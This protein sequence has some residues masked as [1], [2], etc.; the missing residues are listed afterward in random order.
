MP[1]RS[2]DILFVMRPGYFELDEWSNGHGT[3]HGSPW[4]YDTHVPILFFGAGVQHGEVLRRTHITD[5]VPTISAIVGL[6]LTDACTGRTVHEV[7][8]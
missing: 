2:G 7:V 4:N 5:I 6:S 8:K 3:T 1:Q